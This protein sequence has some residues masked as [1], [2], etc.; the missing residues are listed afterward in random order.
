MWVI[1]IKEK[2]RQTRDLHFYIE[3]LLCYTITYDRKYKRT[4]K[5]NTYIYKYI[6]R[7]E[8]N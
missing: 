6:Q 3:Y 4:I 8:I 1:F 2:K 5:D 7:I